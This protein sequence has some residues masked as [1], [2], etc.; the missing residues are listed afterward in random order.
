MYHK[1][2]QPTVVYGSNF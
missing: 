1:A 2:V